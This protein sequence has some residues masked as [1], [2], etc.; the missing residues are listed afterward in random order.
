MSNRKPDRK[1]R[2]ELLGA[3]AALPALALPGALA[4]RRA[5]AGVAGSDFEFVDELVVTKSA[6]KLELLRR[7]RPLRTYRVALGLNPR[8]HKEREGDFRTPEGEYLIYR[9]NPESEFFLSLGISYPNADDLR[10]A[11]RNGWDPGGAIMI[12]GWPNVLKRPADYYR[13]ADWTNGCIALTNEEML[14]V[15]LLTRPDT[16]IAI[17]P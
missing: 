9:R 6:R 3:L 13:S 14:E 5:A 16:P 15:W 10:R 2:R 1:T 7:G 4:P 11:R 12:H 17:R 8:G